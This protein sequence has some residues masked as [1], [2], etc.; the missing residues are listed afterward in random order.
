MKNSFVYTSA[1]GDLHIFEDQGYI[2]KINFA[3][4]DDPAYKATESQAIKNV[5]LQ[6]SQYLGGQRKEFTVLFKLEGTEFQKKVWMELQ[7]IPYGKTRTYGE[8]A[9]RIGNPKAAR[10]VG[11][12]NNKNPLSIIIP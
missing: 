1:I 9:R 8:I 2:T 5:Y 12:A 6:I 4:A 10:A 3:R 11:N 7:N